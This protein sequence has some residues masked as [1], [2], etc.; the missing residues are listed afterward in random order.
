MVVKNL[1]QSKTGFHC[2]RCYVGPCI[3]INTSNNYVKTLLKWCFWWESTEKNGSPDERRTFLKTSVWRGVVESPFLEVLQN[4]GGVTPGDMGSGH[5]GVGWGWTRW[6]CRAFPTGMIQWF[7]G[8]VL[9]RM[10]YI[11]MCIQ[12][13]IT[14]YISRYFVSFLLCT[15]SSEKFH[16]PYPKII[17]VEQEMSSGFSYS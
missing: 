9:S 3:S 14:S 2:R 12:P 17:S 13:S 10:I 8:S 15:V 16:L 5:R 6:S 7:R 11:Q 1:E 4:H